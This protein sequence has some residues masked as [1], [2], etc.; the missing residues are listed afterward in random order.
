VGWRALATLLLSVGP[1]SP[2]LL[3]R[4]DI[5]RSPVRNEGVT[6]EFVLALVAAA[7]RVEKRA[8]RSRSRSSVHLSYCCVKVKHTH[9]AHILH[10][11]DEGRVCRCIKA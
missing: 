7:A 4:G 6:E 5:R 11:S 8:A 3:A 9:R 2:L 10:F 1:D